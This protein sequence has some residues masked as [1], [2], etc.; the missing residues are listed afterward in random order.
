MRVIDT[1]VNNGVLGDHRG[2]LGAV[3]ASVAI[4]GCVLDS[5][6]MRNRLSE[7]T[8]PYLLQ[9]ADNPVHWQA[10]NDEALAAAREAGKPILLSIGY[11]ACHW[12]H[13][14]AH[15]S[16]E[17]ADTA[18]LMNELFVNV[19]VD[20]EERPD[21]DKI[22]QTA[23]Q[24]FAGRAGGWPLTVFLTP[25]RHLPI[26]TGTY[27]PKERRYGMPAFREVLVAVEGYYRTR[28]D[29][30]HKRAAELI[31]ALAVLDSGAG[32][33]FAELSRAPLEAARQRLGQHYDPECGGFG[34]APKFPH[35]T[36]LSLL[37][38]HWARCRAAGDTDERALTIVTHT[39][40]AMA[41]GGL[42]DQLGGGFFR[43]SVDRRWAIPHFEKM[44]YD[45]AALLAI[46]ADGFAATGRAGY[47]AVASATADWGLR[48]MRD[49]G[50]A[51]YST[52]DADSEHEEG[53]FYVWT[54]A[55]IEALLEP[56]EARLAER[57]FGLTEPPSFEGRHWHLHLAESVDSAAAALGF[58]A[59]R[60]ARLLDSAR[61]KLLA[62]RERRVW[63]G[64]DE[65]LLGAWNGLM[66]GALAR[67]A[68]RLG[69]PELA[70]A[71]TGTVDFIR[72]E[73][74]VDGR[75]RAAYKDGRA[76][77]PAYLDDHAFLAMGLVELLQCRWRAE[78]LQLARELLDA[79]LAHFEDSRG[80]FFFTADDHEALI[81]RSKPLADE[82]VPS[83][84]GAAAAAL[85]TLGHL[86]GEQRYI[87][88]AESTVRSAL[89]ALNRY[90]EAHATL[91]FAL[92]ELLEPPTVVV[93]RAAAD[94]LPEWQRVLDTGYAPHR[95]AF[96][97]PADADDLPGLLAERRPAATPIA[98]VCEGTLCRA[99]ITTL[100]ALAA[101]LRS[102]AA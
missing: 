91:L 101:A 66:I 99:P 9:H 80:G 22:Y 27:F 97:I 38:D 82:S 62:A 1:S 14:M 98:Y 8:S 11:S 96:A 60:A 43:Y 29:E 32:D 100:D 40:D 53:K 30:I 71:A 75:L 81:H 87:D 17:D 48:D 84:N 94:S 102:P 90:P 86:L 5:V 70:A 39:L 3:G 61:A 16:F 67:A 58:E 2:V 42:Y 63:P 50:G 35:A 54:P 72:R 34:D 76:R 46:Y 74:F 41:E 26:F 20:R 15:E 13:V 83:G 51:F 23:H 44:L 7:E 49:P 28:G 89:H 69:R 52:L 92:E 65:K 12:C 45:N 25:D 10:W 77:F 68:R 31:D 18:R 37:L 4:A 78:D 33:D 79:L 59:G 57:V 95:A 73:L 19:K 21:L 24:L 93:V 55:E 56:D 88:A 64:R 47:A 85:L 36:Y 6:S